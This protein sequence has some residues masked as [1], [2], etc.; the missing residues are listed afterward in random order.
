VCVCVCLCAVGEAYRYLKNSQ[1]AEKYLNKAY[2]L[3]ESITNNEIKAEIL[4]SLG[5]LY[6][7]QALY[8]LALLHLQRSLQLIPADMVPWRIQYMTYIGVTHIVLGDTDEALSILDQA[9]NVHQQLD[10]HPYITMWLYFTLY[11]AWYSKGDKYK[12]WEYLI[13]AKTASDIVAAE[14]PQN[15]WLQAITAAWFKTWSE[16]LS[17]IWPSLQYI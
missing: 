14:V 1:L 7:S 16:I 12:S 13:K 4:S 15:Q 10:S 3:S 6:Y 9:F 8:P 11:L 2:A 17:S 5:G